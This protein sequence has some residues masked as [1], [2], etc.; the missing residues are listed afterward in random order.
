MVIPVDAFPFLA[1]AGRLSGQTAQQLSGPEEGEVALAP[2]AFLALFGEADPPAPTVVAPEPA[3]TDSPPEDEAADLKLALPAFAVPLPAAP[4]ESPAAPEPERL[5]PATKV[6]EEP[7]TALPDPRGAGPGTMPDAA[8]THARAHW[9][10]DPGQL[11]NTAGRMD[12]PGQPGRQGHEAP[13]PPAA[14]GTPPGAVPVAADATPPDPDRPRAYAAEAP[15]PPASSA[16]PA[17]GK[18]Q[19]RVDLPDEAAQVAALAPPTDGE[20]A[21][22]AARAGQSAV[23]RTDPGRDLPIEPTL[24]PETGRRH[25]EMPRPAPKTDRVAVAAPVREDWKGERPQE[26]FRSEISGL[27]PHAMPSRSVA[28]EPEP[29]AAPEQVEPRTAL[30]GAGAIGAGAIGAGAIG[31]GDLPDSAA[32][33]PVRPEPDITGGRAPHAPAAAAPPHP[34]PAADHGAAVG[35]QL[36]LGLDAHRGGPVEVTLSPE[37][38]GRVRM[39]LQGG[40]AGLTLTLTAERPETLDLMRRHIDQLAQDFRDLGYRNLAF[41]FASDGGQR[42]GGGPMP[43]PEGTPSG[44]ARAEAPPPDVPL[45]TRTGQMRLA[46]EDRLDL[47]L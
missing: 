32:P 7:P 33:A 18:A 43:Q 8:P 22:Q 9:T 45:P 11:P 21:E 40:E 23:G 47:R 16:A 14:R 44:T 27:P 1:P 6:P 37:E 20:R 3:E 19:M 28:V 17:Q 36:A 25:A 13:P 24:A 35:R 46:G 38:L 34:A 5:Q 26:G 2:F 15:L 31:A 39:V 29:D 42:G 41:S 30:S 4:P 12:P 10:I